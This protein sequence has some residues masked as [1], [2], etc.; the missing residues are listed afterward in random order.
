MLEKTL[1]NIH[2]APWSAQEIWKSVIIKCR[3]TYG[4]LSWVQISQQHPG[5]CFRSSSISLNRTVCSNRNYKVRWSE[6]YDN[7]DDDDE[8]ELN[9]DSVFVSFFGCSFVVCCT[10]GA[11]CQTVSSLSFIIYSSL[12]LFTMSPQVPPSPSLPPSFFLS[13]IDLPSSQHEIV[14]LV[15][16]MRGDLTW[17]DSACSVSLCGT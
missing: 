14:L 5:S 16:D 6:E 10:A 3:D 2:L 15:I 12:L 4:T 9:I 13:L 8:E 1:F 7:D 11:S 17:T